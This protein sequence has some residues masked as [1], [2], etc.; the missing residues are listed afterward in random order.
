MNENRTYMNTIWELFDVNVIGI[1]RFMNNG[2]LKQVRIQ[3]NY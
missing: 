2:N 3:V 1:T